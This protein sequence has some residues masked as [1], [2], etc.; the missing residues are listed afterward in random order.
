[1]LGGCSIGNSVHG[2]KAAFQPRPPP[3]KS[4]SQDRCAVRG[5][6]CPVCVVVKAPW[7]RSC[8]TC[9]Q[10]AP[11]PSRPWRQEPSRPKHDEESRDTYAPPDPL[12]PDKQLEVTTHNEQLRS[13][14]QALA[15]I[16]AYGDEAFALAQRKTHEQIETLCAQKKELMDRA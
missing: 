8:G 7:A 13:A 6:S 15:G 2:D 11:K 10:R 12:G 4:A 3:A 5:W 9:S 16:R 14:K 1:M